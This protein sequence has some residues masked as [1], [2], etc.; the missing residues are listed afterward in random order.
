MSRIEESIESETKLLAAWGWGIEGARE[1]QLWGRF[2]FGV[3]KM[4]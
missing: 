4:S 2:L 3:M 1:L